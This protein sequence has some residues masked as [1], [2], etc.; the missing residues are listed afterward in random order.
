MCS[1]NHHVVV[2][3]LCKLNIS[4][5]V[6]DVM[7]WNKISPDAIRTFSSAIGSLAPAPMSKSSTLLLSRLFI[8][9]QT[10]HAES[11]ART[12]KVPHM[13]KWRRCPVW[14]YVFN[15]TTNNV[16]RTILIEDDTCFLNEVIGIDITRT[17][18][19]MVWK[20]LHP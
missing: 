10:H 14:C 4:H 2:V 13:L 11:G 16:V 20:P 8:Y 5:K 1:N 7:E 19:K 15:F 17:E 9:L 18:L 6:P 12:S 3:F